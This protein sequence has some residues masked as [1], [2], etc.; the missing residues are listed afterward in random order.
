MTHQVMTHQKDTSNYAI[1][2]YVWDFVYSVVCIIYCIKSFQLCSLHTTQPFVGRSEKAFSKTYHIQSPYI[3]TY[4]SHNLKRQG[5][6]PAS[7]KH[8]T[9]VMEIYVCMLVQCIKL[10]NLFEIY[11]HICRVDIDISY[12]GSVPESLR[13]CNARPT[14]DEAVASY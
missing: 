4:H 9:L 3:Q 14:R 5:H 11:F 12:W 13:Y 6:L 10:L 1:D 2:F 7:R 8:H